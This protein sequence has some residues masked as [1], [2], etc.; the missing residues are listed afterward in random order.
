MAELHVIGQL[1]SSLQ[2]VFDFASSS[3]SRPSER[4]RYLQD[5][6]AA[7]SFQRNSLILQK[8]ALFCS[9][10]LRCEVL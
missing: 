10:A 9:T 2:H 4:E 1:E 8:P 6:R 7:L 3:A 5:L